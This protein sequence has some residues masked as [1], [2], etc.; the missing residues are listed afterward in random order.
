VDI[1]RATIFNW[2]ERKTGG[3]PISLG[4]DADW[5]EIERDEAPRSEFHLPV[6]IHPVKMGT[7]T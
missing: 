5:I 3:L 1:D 6:A 2:S 7:T 4:R